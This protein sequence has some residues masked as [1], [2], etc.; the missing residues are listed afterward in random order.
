MPFTPFHFGVSLPFIFWDWKKKRVDAISALI[1][2]VIV[3]IRATYLFLFTNNYDYHGILHSFFSAIILGILV[4]IFV[5]LT[6]KQ[7]N[8]LLKWGKWEQDTSLLSKILVA[9][10]FA[11]S[12]ILLDAALYG[13]MNMPM[14][15]LWPFAAGNFLYQWLPSSTVHNICI[16]G[17]VIG[18]MFYVGYLI[19]SSYAKL[20]PQEEPPL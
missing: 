1:G 2:T 19:W 12:H 8:W 14:D 4:G 5:H 9:C 11:T 20:K 6:R 7:W 18:I 13:G 16:I 15:P 3:D 10:I 17:Y